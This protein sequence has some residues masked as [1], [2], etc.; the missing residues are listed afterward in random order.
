MSLDVAVFSL[1]NN[2]AGAS[3][4]FDAALVFFANYLQYVLAFSFVL[5]LY[6]SAY[7]RRIKIKIFWTTILAG[8]I[9]LFGIT[10]LIRLLYHRPRPFITLDA[11]YL[12]TEQSWS[13]PSAHAAFF[14]A[15]AAAIFLYNKKWGIGF[16]LAAVIMNISRVIAGVHYVSDILAGMA[17]GIVTACIV[18]YIA[19]K[20][21][22]TGA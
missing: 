14:F 4:V 7:P 15:V 18:Y 20:T 12:F 6:I 5:L 2:Y 22:K 11:R 13:F 16:F 3:S 10:S 8:G 9:A 17:V 21:G 1:L 19:Q